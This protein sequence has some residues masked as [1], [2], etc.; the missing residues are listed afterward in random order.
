MRKITIIAVLS[1]FVMAHGCLDSPK[2]GIYS[3]MAGFAQGTSYHI[4]CEVPDTI[5]LQPQVDSILQAFDRSLSSYDSN[6][7]ISKI[8][9]NEDLTVDLLFTNVFIKSEEVFRASGGVFDITVMPLVNAWGFGPGKREPVDPARIDS[10]LEFV[11]M[12]KVKIENGKIVKSDP[13]VQIDVNAIAQGYS[14][15]IVAEFFEKMG[16]ENYMVEIGGEIRAKGVNQNGRI[17]RIGIDRP[18]F[19]NMIPGA[20]LEAI[21]ELKN[22]SLATSGNYRKFYEENGIKYTHSIDPETGYPSKH[23]LLSATI[24]TDDCMTADAYATVCMVGGLEK[25][26]EI[27]KSHP[28]LEGFLIYGDGETGEYRLYVTEGMKKWVIEE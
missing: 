6:S 3:K 25:S 22:K 10:L 18:D 21:V 12:E 2:T 28:E 8:N 23:S 27:L 26:K 9:R 17:W 13:R 16:S 5:D 1:V 4:T 24:V 15:D 11:G 19:G 7:V 14:V 20:E